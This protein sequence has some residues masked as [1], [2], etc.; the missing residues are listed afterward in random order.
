VTGGPTR[1]RPEG[2]DAVRPDGESRAFF[3]AQQ[4]R[5]LN[6]RR[7]LLICAGLLLNGV[8]LFTG[9]GQTSVTIL[10]GYAAW[11]VTVV[12]LD[13]VSTRLATKR[14]LVRFSTFALLVDLLFITV[15]MYATGGGWW[16]G[17]MFQCV[18]VAIAATTLPTREGRVVFA[19]AIVAWSALILGPM[20]GLFDPAPWFGLPSVSDNGPLLVS[21]H[22][23]GV[24]ALFATW[25]LLRAHTARVRRASES[26]ARMVEASP[27]AVLTFGRDARV[28]AA[29]PASL[30]L[31]DVDRAEVIGRGML[32]FVPPEDRARVVE[33]FDRTL[34]GEVTHLEHGLCD[35]DGG[36]HWVSVTYSP[37][38]EPS[39]EQTV[40]AIG[41]DRSDERRADAERAQLQ[42]ELDESHRMRL[43]GRLVSGVAHELNN[44]LAAVMSFTEQ[45]LADAPDAHT[46]EVLGV[47]HQQAE[48]AR[49]I[50]RDLLQVV[51]DRSDR[52]PAPTDLGAL[53]LSCLRAME[54]AARERRVALEARVGAAGLPALVDPTGL[55]QV[56]DNLVRNAVLAAATPGRVVV[57]VQFAAGDGWTLAVSDDGPGVPAEVMAHLFEPFYTTRAPGE[58]T[59]LGLAV[60]LGIVERH[61]GTIAVENG[62][63]GS[64]VGARFVVRLPA[65]L[66]ADRASTPAPALVAPVRPAHDQVCD[67]IDAPSEHDRRP[68]LL[69]VDDEPAI[70]MA[71]ERFL[72]RRGWTV[73]LCTSGVDASELLLADGAGARIDVVL[74]DLKMPG[75]NGIALYHLLERERPVFLGRLVFATGDV[76]SADVATFLQGVRCPVL[77]KPFALTALLDVLAVASAHPTAAATSPA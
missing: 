40:M 4:L 10:A 50:V 5:E 12:L 70:R 52:R 34:R 18:I 66:V 29:N 27:Y 58:G 39:G 45:L 44:P 36:V 23:L 68:H 2:A 25:R 15:L 38:V 32:R 49:A 46:R 6:R 22:G 72:T 7:L 14:R 53:V 35:S 9:L 75:M 21:L 17:A 59:G 42:R 13:Q 24:L 54:P 74:C 16:Q 73:T 43:V 48:R 67:A 41:R 76:A 60:S 26:N 20:F 61:G 51:R 63:P 77:E 19:S 8:F 30:R 3:W 47:M 57:D 69:L 71:L 33:A 1:T 56:L 64:G 11:L 37:L 28:L 55:A 62:E 65:A 31:L